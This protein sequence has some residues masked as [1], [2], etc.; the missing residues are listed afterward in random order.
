[1]FNFQMSKKI[2]YDNMKLINSEIGGFILSMTP[3]AE[4]G[5]HFVTINLLQLMNELIKTGQYRSDQLVI[6]KNVCLNNQLFLHY[7]TI[8][9]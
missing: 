3:F 4:L 2:I 1:M 9:L 8:H 7:H 6:N 5:K